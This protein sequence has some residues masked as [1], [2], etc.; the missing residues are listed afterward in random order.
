MESKTYAEIHGQYK[1]L[2]KTCELLSGRRS[3]CKAYF[4]K[5]A[6]DQIVV[7]G[8]GSS[9][10]IAESIAMSARLRTGVA[11][12]PLP[13]GDLMLRIDEYAPLF[14]GKTL[15]ISLSRSGSTSEALYAVRELKKK[16]DGISVCS[17]AC[18]TDSP[19]NI[20]SD[21]TIEIPWA[22]DESVCQTR[23]VTNLYAA[24][25]LFIGAVT[26]DDVLFEHYLGLAKDG[27]SYLKT[28]EDA[29]ADIG[30]E[31][32][33]SAAILCD[34]EGFGV[35]KEAALAFNE[36]AYTHSTYKHVL[37]VRH[38]P[39]V[40]F[41]A[42]TLVVIQ[43]DTAEFEYQKSLVQDVLK[44]GAQV[45]LVSDTK[46]PPVEGVRAQIVFGR[47]FHPAAVGA[48]L[49]PVAQ[50]LAYYHALSIDANPDQPDGLDAWIAL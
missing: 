46:L 21:F 35:G 2:E 50:M 48:L 47:K 38:G 49:L 10:Q 41:N 4:N 11:S 24:A 6:P 30:R 20:E 28:V 23:S 12:T 26:D 27:E 44:R 43:I 22:F 1:A 19:I 45:I 25:M 36:I 18:T 15:V 31:G 13:G 39:I 3:E 37:D 14:S 5:T 29:V 33:T 42:K 8:C 32:W 40:L 9:F 34:G 17:I 7:I 16:F